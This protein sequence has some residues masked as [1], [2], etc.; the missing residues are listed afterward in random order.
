M[1]TRASAHP[2]RPGGRDGGTRRIGRAGTAA[3]AVVGIGLVVGAVVI[4]VGLVDALVGFVAVPLVVIVALALR[5][6]HAPPLRATDRTGH[7]LNCAAGAAFFVV[8]PVGAMLFY[9]TSML[10][11][12]LTGNAGCEL[13]V[14]SNVLRRRDDRVGCAVFTPVDALD[15][16]DTSVTFRR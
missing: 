7:C 12:A 6:R 15:R 13:T 4:G 8:L 14:V 16:V 2:A 9:G 1:P 5:G 3:R 10:V 11:A